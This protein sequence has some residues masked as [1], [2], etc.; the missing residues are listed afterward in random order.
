MK[1]LIGIIAGAAVIHFLS[2]DQGKSLVDKLKDQAGDLGSDL[3][4]KGTSLFSAAK[5]QAGQAM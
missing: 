1:F 5:D 4:K 3:L 2:T